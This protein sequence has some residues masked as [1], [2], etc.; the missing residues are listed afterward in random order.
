MLFNLFL[1]AIVKSKWDDVLELN[2][3]QTSNSSHTLVGNKIVDHS[4]EVGASPL[5]AAPTTSSFSTQ[6]LASIDGTKATARDEKH[7]ILV[8]WCAYI[9]DLTVDV[10]SGAGVIRVNWKH[11]KRSMTKNRKNE[12]NHILFHR[13]SRNTSYSRLVAIINLHIGSGQFWSTSCKIAIMCM[14]HANVYF[15]TTRFRIVTQP[16]SSPKVRRLRTLQMVLKLCTV[17]GTA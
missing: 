4:D 1:Y 13:V 6:R 7:L 2:Y 8:I 16:R 5:G 17:F 9:R 11:S 14:P 15:E 10:F 12:V 3:R